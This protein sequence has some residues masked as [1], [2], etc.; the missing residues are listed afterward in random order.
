MIFPKNVS[1][2]RIMT[3]KR[4]SRAGLVS[5]GRGFVGR[6][7]PERSRAENRSPSLSVAQLGLSGLLRLVIVDA[8]VLRGLVLAGPAVCA[9][10]T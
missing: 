8:T 3:R 4:Q 6:T 10:L 2:F 5:A 7:I 9:A 1:T